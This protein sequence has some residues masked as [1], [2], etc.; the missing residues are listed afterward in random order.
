MLNEV[1]FFIGSYLVEI[2][3]AETGTFTNCNT[4]DY[5]VRRGDVFI[6]RGLQTERATQIEEYRLYR[7]LL[8]AEIVSPAGSYSWLSW[9][10]GP[11]ELGRDFDPFAESAC[12]VGISG[13]WHSGVT[14]AVVVAI[15][16]EAGP[17]GSAG[18]YTHINT[19][20]SFAFSSFGIAEFAIE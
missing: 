19:T 4:Q 12:S 16:G 18:H 20:A 13:G 14:Y 15:A 10:S 5:K 11:V 7:E 3:G 9:T 2:P 6:G 1:H 17:I 8:R